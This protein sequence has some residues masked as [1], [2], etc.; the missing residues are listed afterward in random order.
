MYLKKSILAKEYGISMTT[1]SERIRMIRDQT[2]KRYPRGAIITT[3]R[4]IRIRDDVFEDAMINGDAIL[5]GIAPDFK[6][7]ERHA[8]EEN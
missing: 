2:P 8:W 7:H 4:I 1:V 5:C 6:P 3:G